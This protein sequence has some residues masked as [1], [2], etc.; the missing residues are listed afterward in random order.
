MGWWVTDR[1]L[2]CIEIIEM[3]IGGGF[4]FV[5]VFGKFF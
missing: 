4:L 3:K 1:D 5:F 2:V